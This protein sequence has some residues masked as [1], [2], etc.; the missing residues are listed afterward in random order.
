MPISKKEI[1]DILK[2]G[3]KC[4]YNV[5]DTWKYLNRE[6][7]KG[8]IERCFISNKKKPK[9]YSHGGNRRNFTVEQRAEREET[10]KS[11]RELYIECNGDFKKIADLTG[12]AHSTLSIYGQE[13]GLE[14]NGIKGA[15]GPRSIYSG[16]HEREDLKY[17]RRKRRRP[18]SL[19]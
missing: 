14:A 9:K 6:Y 8:T 11:I 7:S 16:V 15:K 4:E 5:T 19:V 17:R 1:S 10:E 12:K 3:K 2:A 18:F 13:M